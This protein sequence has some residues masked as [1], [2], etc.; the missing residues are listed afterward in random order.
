MKVL[1]VNWGLAETF[2]QCCVASGVWHSF[3]HWDVTHMLGCTNEPLNT[4]FGT[5]RRS[6]VK[7]P[8]V[9]QHWPYLPRPTRMSERSFSMPMKLLADPLHT[10]LD[11]RFSHHLP[12]D[13]QA[14]QVHILHPPSEHRSPQRHSAV[15]LSVL[16]IAIRHSHHSHGV[17][18][19]VSFLTWRH[20]R[21]M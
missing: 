18:H 8:A 5:K 16:S 13:C 10:S 12:S 15:P 14:E 21:L 19:N 3:P 7:M 9:R 11:I 4:S 1:E 2:A 6:R 20:K 17:Q